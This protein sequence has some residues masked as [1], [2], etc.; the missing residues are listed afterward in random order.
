MASL[1]I[2]GFDLLSKKQKVIINQLKNDPYMLRTL[3]IQ[4]NKKCPY[5][6]GILQVEEQRQRQ[7]QNLNDMICKV[8]FNQPSCWLYSVPICL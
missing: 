8:E 6:A 3:V 1:N 2:K 4:R 5:L 7:I